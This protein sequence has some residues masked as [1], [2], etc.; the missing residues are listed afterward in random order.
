[1]K[2]FVVV[3]EDDFELF[4]NGL[5][6][7]A[8]LQYLPALAFMNILDQR[9]IKVSF[10]VDAAQQLFF[11][12]QRASS[13]QISIQY[14]LWEQTVK[15]M[16]ERGHDVQ[17]HIHPQWLGAQ[18]KGDHFYLSNRWN[19]GQYA[20]PQQQQLVTDSVSYL[21]ELLRPIDPA[22]KVVGY[23]AG[24]WGMQP[25]KSLME[26]LRD[27][28][29]RV[30]MGARDGMYIPENGVDFREM[31]EPSLPYHPDISDLTK[32]SSHRGDPV[33]LPMHGYAPSLLALLRLSAAKFAGRSRH[34]KR[35][36]AFYQR[37]PIPSEISKL[38]PLRSRQHLRP[39]LRPYLTHL[40]IGDA[41]SSYLRASFDS[42]V[43]RLRR[44]DAPRIPIVIESHTKQ[45][46]GYYE[47]IERFLDHVL[48]RYGN[49]VEF[50]TVSGIAR[51]L[52][53]TP[54]MARCRNEDRAA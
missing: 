14:S 38:S 4:G 19:L 28:G 5:G 40:K 31:E 17:L 51:E 22:Y 54:G 8:S 36:M 34:V 9:D 50:G 39:S 25:S 24:S 26:I 30:V 18:V 47:D 46:P 10:M 21:H 13:S 53:A 49:E 15:A 23:K 45:F 43:S 42:V 11:E 3:I 33:M 7:V 48:D 12:P 35:E 2:K 20:Q 16:L 29:V 1:M 52:A 32:V 27:C 44:L 6:N 37:R 41:P